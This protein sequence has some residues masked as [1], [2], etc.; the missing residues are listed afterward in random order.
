MRANATW[1]FVTIP[2]FEADA[3]HFRQQTGAE[4]INLVLN[5]TGE[6]REAW[7]KYAIEHYEA[8]IQEAHL[9]QKGSLERLTPV[10]FKPFISKLTQEGFVPQDRNSEYFA[11]WHYTP[12][13]A[14][15]GLIGFD[16]LAVPD[17]GK[18]KD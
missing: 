1:P 15:Y 10:G 18:S 4:L 6:Q 12:P 8:M 11:S 17:Y 9:V 7:E 13:P 5:V 14:T 2:N 3:R 16:A